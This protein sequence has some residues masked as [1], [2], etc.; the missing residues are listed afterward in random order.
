[1]GKVLESV[2]F[3]TGNTGL[4][5][6][7]N[8][9]AA[10]S[11]DHGADALLLLS[12][13]LQGNIMPALAIGVEANSRTFYKN[14]AFST[15][16]LWVTP[17]V[18]VR[19]PVCLSFT[20]GCDISAAK[21]R[22][23]DAAQRSLE[24]YRIFGDAVLSYDFLANKRRAAAEKAKADSTERAL[25]FA[26]AKRCHVS[27]DSLR[28]K[29]NAD[30]LRHKHSIDSVQAV[31]AAL[32]RKAQADSVT[33]VELMAEAKRLLALEKERRSDLEKKLLTTG[34]L[35][36]DAVYFESGKTEISMNS[37]PY[38]KIIGKM[39]ERY[40][41]LQ[42]EVGG[43]TDNRGLAE[44][45]QQ[46]SQARSEA[47]RNYLIEV[48]PDLSSRLSAMGYGQSVP[49]ADNRTAAGRKVNRRVEIKVLNPEVL[50]EYN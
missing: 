1:M 26:D 25:C 40:P 23:N 17:S 11:T 19:T 6:H 31:L 47:V 38:L 10:Q 33:N 45:N 35:I 29:A 5:I 39:L 28:Q 41:K 7:L 34:M 8:E 50:K 14:R 22:T 49:K 32:V 20:L 48:A 16:P 37:K 9:G 30:A 15:D 13:G 44:K 2:V 42:L 3:G 18:I 46:L 27:G 36:L 24:R 4:Q 43:H 21:K 12:G